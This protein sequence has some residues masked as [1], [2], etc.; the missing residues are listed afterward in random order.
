MFEND[1]IESLLE[2]IAQALEK[3]TTDVER[4]AAALEN[5]A[6]VHTAPAGSHPTFDG[7]QCSEHLEADGFPKWVIAPTG[8][9]ATL[10]RGDG[11]TWYSYYA[12]E[13]DGKKSYPKVLKFKVGDTAPA[14]KFPQEPPPPD[15]APPPAQQRQEPPKEEEHG[16]QPPP[17]RGGSPA[18]NPPSTPE[19]RKK[20]HNL[21]RQHHGDDWSAIGPELIAGITQGRTRSSFEMHA[22]EASELIVTLAHSEVP[23]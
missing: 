11:E 6:P 7:L 17:A 8:E 12:G 2:R 20:I 14:V 16:H 19:Q 15:H 23:F 18:V 10:K 3:N 9:R 22:A 13:V 5:G 21:G 1:A 4:I